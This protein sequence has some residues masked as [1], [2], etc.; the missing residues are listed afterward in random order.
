MQRR[1]LRHIRFK[2]KHVFVI[3]SHTTFLTSVG[4]VN[5]LNL[6]DDS[7][8]FVYI[9]SYRNRVTKIPFQVV[10]ATDLANSSTQIST[11]YKEYVEEVDGFVKQ[12]IG[13]K[14]CL[15]VPHLWNYFFQLLYTNRLCRRVSYVQE[16]GAVQTKVYEVKV[17]LKYRMRSWVRHAILGRRTFEC[18][19]YQK[20]TI[21]KQFSL[22]SYA[23]NDVYFHSLP[24]HNHIVK[25]PSGELDMALDADAPIFIFDGYVKNGLVESEVYMTLC[26]KLIAEQSEKNNYVKFHPA[27][28][29]EEREAIL[30][31]FEKQQKKVEIMSDEIP[32]EYVIIQFKNLTFVGFTSSLLYYAHDFGHKVICNEEALLKASSEFRSYVKNCGFQTFAETYKVQK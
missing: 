5:Y 4:V 3:N 32:M 20:G 24:S 11:H 2:M 30:S 9:R 6:A 7:V 22:D 16:G 26:E 8:I 29:T 19:W 15:Y 13:S 14:Y 27:Q 28:N 17:P 23:V 31:F 1:Y 25:W 18:K 21:Y 10:D 12:V